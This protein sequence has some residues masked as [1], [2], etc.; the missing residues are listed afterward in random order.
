MSN[1]LEAPYAVQDSAAESQLYTRVALRLIPF[2]FICYS[3][4]R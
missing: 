1:T 4:L 3:T 2:L